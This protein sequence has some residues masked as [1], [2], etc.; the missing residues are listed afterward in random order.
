[1]MRANG[2]FI[3]NGTY[4]KINRI[5]INTTIKNYLLTVKL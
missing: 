4:M 3:I 1:M 5:K 2:K